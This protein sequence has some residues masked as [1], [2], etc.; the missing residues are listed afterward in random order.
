MILKIKDTAEDVGTLEL[1]KRSG[2]EIELIYYSPDGVRQVLL[3]I[4]VDS[5][6]IFA[7]RWPQGDVETISTVRKNGS[8]TLEIRGPS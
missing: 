8:R 7:Y 3:E 2:G 6:K 4:A 5:G 1:E